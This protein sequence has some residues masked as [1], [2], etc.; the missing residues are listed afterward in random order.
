MTKLP[1]SVKGQQLIRAL[2][3]LGFVK[4]SQRGSHVR[5]AH[6]DGRWTQVAIH[7]KPV[8]TGTLRVIL[9]QTEVSLEELLS[10]L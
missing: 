3:K 7:P 2:G 8:P 9:R 10:N 6:A 4:V 5:M 1:R